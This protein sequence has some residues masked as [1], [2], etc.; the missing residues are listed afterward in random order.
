MTMTLDAAIELLEI[1][2]IDKITEDELKLRR[3]RTMARWHP[4]IVSTSDEETKARYERNFKNIEPA[5]LIIYA[6]R[7][8]TYFAGQTFEEGN[9]VD[10]RFRQQEASM[11]KEAPQWKTSILNVWDRIKSGGW[12][13][14]VKET[15]LTD[16]FKVREKLREDIKDDIPALSVTSMFYGFYAFLVFLIPVLLIPYLAFLTVPVLLIHLL[17]CTLLFLP[18]SRIWLPVWLGDLAI[19]SCNIGLKIGTF[20]FDKLGGLRIFRVLINWPFYFAKGMTLLIIMPIYE[21]T[22]Y[23]LREKKIGLKKRRERYFGDYPE[24]YVEN[25]L[26]KDISELSWQEL[27]YLSEI[28]NLSMKFA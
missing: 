9:N 26:K 25:L 22:G 1:T 24:F 4:D 11:Q 19:K 6:Y 12:M 28:Y 3:R 21:L 7:T 27:K 14:T 10:L 13:M 16:G 20:V 15:V 18:L 5:I 2:D 8:G 17:L 23:L